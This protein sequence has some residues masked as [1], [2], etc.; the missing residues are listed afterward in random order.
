MDGFGGSG[1]SAGNVVVK[2]RRSTMLRRPR[3]DASPRSSTPSSD[4]ASK[5]SIDHRPGYDASIRKKEFSLNSPAPL[6]SSLGKTE[7]LS[8]QRKIRKE[9]KKY[10]NIDSFYA[11][12]SSKSGHVGSDSK[13]GL[14]PL[15]GKSAV[16][17]K[18]R[19]LVPDSYV[20]KGGEGRR[21]SQSVEALTGSVENKARRVKL[22]VSG[23]TRTI[24]VKLENDNGGPSAKASRSSDA[25]RH[26]QKL[27]L[28]DS[29]DGDHAPAEKENGL[30]LAPWKGSHVGGSPHG[31]NEGSKGKAQSPQEL[32]KPNSSSLSESVR[33]SR[34]MP[35]RRV[36]DG[37]RDEDDIHYRK[38]LKSSRARTDYNDE[39]ENNDFVK[40]KKISVVS[41]SKKTGYDV[42]DDY[43][44]SQP[45]RDSRKKL[46][47][48]KESEDTD[49]VEEE[50]LG[51]DDES[52]ANRTQQREVLDRDSK[53]EPLTTRQRSNKGGGGTV[54]EFPDG[55]P[56][57]APKRPKEKLSEMEQQ[58]KKAEAAQRRRMQV[59]K[60][61]KE[62]EAE[63]IRKILGQDSTKKKKEDK[64]RKE[65][66]EKAQRKAE[67]ALM[68]APGTTRWIIGPTGTVVKFAD[69]VGLPS[70]FAGPRSYP[71]PRE[72]CAGPS[73]T[74]AYKYRDSKLNLPLCSLQC[75][76]AVKG[77]IPPVSTC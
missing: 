40:K 54:I 38:S 57:T 77:N 71:P 46:R 9:D 22:K 15:N 16:K 5:Y 34:R 26:R 10:G 73:C 20:G 31:A 76:K 69:D 59:E 14:A 29:S 64:E 1:F 28:Q 21:M 33:K 25:P 61:A 47:T 35:K 67:E 39:N 30:R 56:A 36:L 52:N 62:L 24:D 2:K 72:K 65:R 63:A 44:S 42:D 17:L 6:S 74:N 3:P 4:N 18:D 43:G 68:L 48:G 19:N 8:S 23:V 45:T 55:L 41:K 60:Q 58:A 11:H 27:I 37:D 66:E 13:R 75:Y 53:N 7:G 49:F 70:I 12:G 51:S 32:D 50:E